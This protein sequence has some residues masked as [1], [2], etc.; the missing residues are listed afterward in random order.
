[1]N[2]MKTDPEI[3]VSG[4]TGYIGQA[5]IPRLVER[6]HAVTALARV[7]SEAR[8]PSV[9]T[10]VIG[11]ALDAG[12]FSCDGCDT[13]VHLVGT[14][15]PA[16]W[17]GA[18]FRS[19]DLVALRAS[20][21]A[22][23]RAGVRH[24]VFLSVAQPAPVMRAYLE[25]RAECERIIRDAG[26]NATIL[27]PWYVLGPGHWWPAALMPLYWLAEQVESTRERSFGRWTI[28]RRARA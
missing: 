14:P 23:V 4:G 10:V 20:V 13:F 21:V 27:R 12:S 7:S 9:A 22:A 28:H 24:F 8:V 1:M 5:V 6:G 17:K 2:R 11:D 19:V 15:H 16:P 18:Q 3:F 26:L 25:V